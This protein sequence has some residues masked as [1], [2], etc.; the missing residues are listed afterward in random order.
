M[1][2]SESANARG[3]C[4]E[5]PIA[6]RSC[7]ES[8]RSLL[9]VA[10]SPSGIVQIICNVCSHVTFLTAHQPAVCPDCAGVGSHED[11]CPTLQKAWGV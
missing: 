5:H 3:A 4:Y 6:C 11:V 2:T 10:Q 7:G 8:D 1:S 9:D